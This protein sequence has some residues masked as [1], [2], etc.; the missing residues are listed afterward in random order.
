MIFPNM[1]FFKRNICFT[2]L[3][4][5]IL[6]GEISFPVSAVSKNIAEKENIQ[7]SGGDE[8]SANKIG[9]GLSFWYAGWEPYWVKGLGVLGGSPYK[10]NPAVLFGPVVSI[11]FK[12]NLSLSGVFTYGKFKAKSVGYIPIS[13]L[14]GAAPI[15]V[16]TKRE[17]ARF[18]LDLTLLYRLTDYFRLYIGLKYLGYKLDDNMQMMINVMGFTIPVTTKTAIFHNFLGP[19]LGISLTVP[20]ISNW[21]FLSNISGIAQFGKA[22]Q[23]GSQL[24]SSGGSSTLLYYGLNA[25]ANIAYY[26][27]KL[28]TTFALGGRFQYLRINVMSSDNH[29]AGGGSDMFYGITFFTVYM[30]EL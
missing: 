13:M 3:F 10:I 25:T 23:E 2:M 29:V 1:Q 18:D 17:A 9:I 16:N 5:M 4:I 22:G 19:G 20:I 14:M 6:A 24:I 12:K 8:I 11:K 26:A 30:F 7:Y 27:H 28:K 15:F 21:Y